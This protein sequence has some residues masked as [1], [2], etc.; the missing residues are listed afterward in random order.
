MVFPIFVLGWIQNALKYNRFKSGI[1]I[2]DI[3]NTLKIRRKWIF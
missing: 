1:S 3:Y 2:F